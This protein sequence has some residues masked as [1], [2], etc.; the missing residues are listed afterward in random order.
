[1]YLGEPCPVLSGSVR[2]LALAWMSVI[3]QMGLSL[4]SQ[5]WWFMMGTQESQG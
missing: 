3:S 2:F 5:G 1:M 4:S